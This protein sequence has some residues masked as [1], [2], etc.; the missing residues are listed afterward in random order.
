MDR[1]TDLLNSTYGATTIMVN[2]CCVALDDSVKC[3][4]APKSR[5]LSSK[6]LIALILKY[7]QS[8]DVKIR[9]FRRNRF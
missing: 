5:I 4:I 9:V 3:K 8:L 1:I 2:K 7:F 6:D